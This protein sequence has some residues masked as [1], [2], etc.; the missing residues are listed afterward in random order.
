VNSEVPGHGSGGREVLRRRGVDRPWS[1]LDG[2]SAIHNEETKSFQIKGSHHSQ[3]FLA[4]DLALNYDHIILII[5]VAD[6]EA[7]LAELE[8]ILGCALQKFV[9]DLWGAHPSNFACVW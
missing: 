2:A 8:Q 1:C 5:L 6:A 7:S 4:L 9:S 3:R